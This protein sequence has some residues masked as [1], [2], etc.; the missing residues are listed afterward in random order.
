MITGNSNSTIPMQ[1]RKVPKNGDQLSALG[2]GAMRLP[3]M[4]GRIDEERAKKQIRLAIDNGVNYIDTAFLYHDGQS[5]EFLGRA[6]QD[7]YR[8]KIKLATKLPPSEV[9][10]REDMDTILDIQL[11]KLHTG[12]IDYYLL[13][14]L[15]ATSW[16]KLRDLGVLGFLKEAQA[17]GKIKNAGFSFHG[18]RQTFKEIIDAYDWVF[19]QIQYNFL[20]EDIQAGTEGLHYAASKNIAVMVMEPLRG[21]ML[22]RLPKEVKKIY[23]SADKNRSAA[24]WG[25]RWVWNHPEVT[26]VL[27]GMNHEDQVIGNIQTCRDALPGSMTEAELA[28]VSNV[29]K[30]YKQLIKVG[31]N[32]CAYC[33]PC[34]T[35][36]NIPRC[37][38][39]YNQYFTTDRKLK[40]RA[41]YALELM[42]G[43]GEPAD[44]SLCKNCGKCE[45]AC[46]QQIAIPVEL[47]NVSGLLGGLPTK[48][49]LPGI[50]FLWFMWKMTMNRGSTKDER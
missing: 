45:K 41:S 30:S 46:P 35:G 26:V 8:Q 44:A 7:G 1:Y 28:V 6:L 20:D 9:K 14:G 37:F 34:P 33:M 23:D 3:V 10:K 39:L 12:C 11:R 40:T 42:G 21:G 15:E 47:K 32:G 4:K 27:S 13:H 29:A 2:F 16:K 24:E 49:L 43:S 36:V 5:E 25:L 50:T 48:I 22:T 19:C 31:C 17:A 38:S 18:S